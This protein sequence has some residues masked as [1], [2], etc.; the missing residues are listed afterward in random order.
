M[1]DYRL[2]IIMIH[3]SH[4]IPQWSLITWYSRPVRYYH[5]HFIAEETNAD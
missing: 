2:H 3:F 5:P 4:S 1:H